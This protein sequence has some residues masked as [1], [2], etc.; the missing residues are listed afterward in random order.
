MKQSD[1]DKMVEIPVIRKPGMTSKPN[2]SLEEFNARY[3]EYAAPILAVERAAC[4]AGNS[5]T[6][7]EAQELSKQGV[8]VFSMQEFAEFWRPGA[9]PEWIKNH[10]S[11]PKPVTA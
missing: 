5:L 6:W 1:F 2:E 11:Y 10:P 9:E 4:A 8:R 7:E 3:R